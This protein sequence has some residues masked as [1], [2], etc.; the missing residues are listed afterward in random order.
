MWLASTQR[1][2]TI[3]FVASNHG[4]KGGLNLWGEEII[5][6]AE[7]NDIFKNCE[8][9]KIFIFGQCYSGIFGSGLKLSNAAICCACGEQEESYPID[10]PREV[11]LPPNAQPYDAFLYYMIGAL[12]G[13]H[14]K[15]TLFTRRCPMLE[16]MQASKPHLS[17]SQRT[18]TGLSRSNFEH[19]P[20]Q[21]V[22]CSVQSNRKDRTDPYIARPSEGQYAY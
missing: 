5:T 7:M 8:A 1:E 6:P 22:T 3:V 9:T 10:V 16:K 11:K 17:S 14:P 2:D 18:K 12:A 13:H 15:Q 21:T 20:E 19:I 4:E